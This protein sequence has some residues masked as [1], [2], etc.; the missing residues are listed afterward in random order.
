[1]WA[2]GLATKGYISRIIRRTILPLDLQIQTQDV[3]ELQIQDKLTFNINASNVLD[4]NI[5][6]KL[7]DK[8]INVKKSDS[9]DINIGQ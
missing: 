9:T 8:N 4:K 3:L 6:L 5:N 1:M 7:T 2:I